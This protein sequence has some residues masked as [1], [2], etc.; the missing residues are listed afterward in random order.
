VFERLRNQLSPAGELTLDQP[1]RE[2]DRACLKHRLVSRQRDRHLVGCFLGDDPGEFPQG[3]RGHVGLKRLLERALQSAVLDA[4]PVGVGGD[5]RE[6][7]ALRVHEDTGED[8]P[9]F[10]TRRGAGDALD[11]PRQRRRG[12][13]CHGGFE[14]RQ[15]REVLHRQNAKMEPRP[16]CDKLDVS[17]LGAH[18]QI[19]LAWRKAPHHVPEQASRDEHRSPSLNRQVRD[20]H[21][22]PKLAVARLQREALRARVEL[23][24]AQ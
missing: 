20:R 14:L 13:C 21:R 23:N 7:L 4:Q 5:H 8:R 10:V 24:S 1:R 16:A 3:P 2:D 15:A 19:H 11:R 18:A 6:G 9:H 12:K 22:E 17:L